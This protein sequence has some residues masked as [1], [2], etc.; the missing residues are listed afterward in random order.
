MPDGDGWMDGSQAGASSCFIRHPSNLGLRCVS[1][2]LLSVKWTSKPFHLYLPTYLPTYLFCL[3][4]PYNLPT[5]LPNR[6]LRDQYVC[7]TAL[8]IHF[9]FG[10]WNISSL[11]ELLLRCCCCTTSMY[12][13]TWLSMIAWEIS[14]RDRVGCEGPTLK[15]AVKEASRT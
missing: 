15:R 12:G 3:W 6:R 10:H 14:R 11:F 5:Y 13:I 4:I 7:M 2:L 1:A 9:Y 8:S